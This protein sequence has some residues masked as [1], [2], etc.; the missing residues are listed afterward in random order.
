ML[1]CLAPITFYQPY[2]FAAVVFFFFLFLLYFARE[3]QWLFFP[4]ND[5]INEEFFQTVNFFITQQNFC[6]LQI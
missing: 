3:D 1:F 6:L 4:K 5:V 2:C